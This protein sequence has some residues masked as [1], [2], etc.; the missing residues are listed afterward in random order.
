MS[1]IRTKTESTE[2]QPPQNRA[3]N[4]SSLIATAGVV[5]E[6]YDFMLFGYL[7]MVW[8]AVFFPSDDQI[9]S[10]I[11]VWST[12]AVGMAMR[13]LGGIFFGYFGTR[14]G[15]KR[16]L[17]VSVVLMSVPMLI[18][19]CLPSFQSIGIIAPI[20]VVLMRMVQGFSVG[21]EYSGSVVYLVERAPSDKRGMLA[22]SANGASGFGALLASIVVGI[23][24]GTLSTEAINSWGWRIAYLLGGLLVILAIL[25]RRHMEE[26][27]AYLDTK[28]KN[29]LPA[30]PLRSAVKAEWRKMLVAMVITGYAVSSFFFTLNYLPAFLQTIDD[31]PEAETLVLA[32]VLSAIFAFT[33]PFWGSVGDRF[34]RKAPMIVAAGSLLILAWPVF[35]LIS[36]PSILLMYIAAIILLIPTMMY[37]GG[38]SPAVVEMFDKKHRFA[39]VGISYNMGAAIFG[40]TSGVIVTAL[41]DWIDPVLGPA[42]F[43]APFSAV[44]LILCLKLKETAG[45]SL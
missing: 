41:A 43:L 35:K 23:L 6:F 26:S 17:Q 9:L 12:F 45:K 38:F 32:A 25:M 37:W 13:P 1:Q 7:T 16:S 29:E 8:T 3:W 14:F 31:R 18:T 30:T 21:G 40:G 22:N 42:L 27:E 36:H 24:V 4:K 11:F 20:I 28:E 2:P 19:A 39:A 5:V 34:G 10:F 44:T 15:R 33:A